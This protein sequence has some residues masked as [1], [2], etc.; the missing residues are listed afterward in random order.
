MHKKITFFWFRRDLRLEDNT[1]LYKAL[2]GANPVQCV[3]I[4]DTT[5]LS[6]LRDKKDSRVTFIFDRIHHLHQELKER[7]SSLLVKIGEPV[8][9]WEKL[10]QT[11]TIED[12]WTNRDYEPY[13]QQR[14]KE[15]YEL[16]KKKGIGF[17]G[18]RDH[19]IFEKSEVMKDDGTPYMVFTPYSKKWKKQFT[20][21][22]I[23]EFSSAHINNWHSSNFALPSL[24]QIGFAYYRQADHLP[25]I[26]SSVITKYHETRDL[27]AV[28]GTTRLGVHLRFGTISVRQVI[29]SGLQNEKYLNEL[30]WR[31]FYAM[32]LYHYPHVVGRS[33]N[34]KYDALGWLNDESDFE[35]WKSGCTG[36]PLVDAG[37]RELNQT[38]YMHNRVRMVVASFLVKHLLVDWR[39]GES[40]FAEK[41]LD[42]ELA[43]NNGGWQWAAG[44]GVDAAP[45]FRVFNPVSQAKKFDPKS[46]YI[47]SWVPE[48]LSSKYPKPI[49]EL[50]FG[51]NRCLEWY[52]SALLKR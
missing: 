47:K 3:F 22:R 33:F 15:V 14:D 48:V 17:R 37:M 1:A 41:L 7:G 20:E 51:R 29:K 39:W 50:S 18:M 38:G 8:D 28:Q 9:I 42:F 32:I 35:R 43:S 13:A 5:I 26:N 16:L 30:I 12:V 52:K 4:F 31:E 11:Y 21:K 2:N 40:Y 6:K 34:P 46:E 45:Y 23:Q 49:V 25:R 10:S 24:G 19:V 27:P 36:I 44:T